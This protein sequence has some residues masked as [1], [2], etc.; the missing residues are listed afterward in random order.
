MSKLENL[1]KEELLEIVKEK[2]IAKKEEVEIYDIEINEKKLVFPLRIA[3]TD[4]ITGDK[5]TEMKEFVVTVSKE[6]QLA[7]IKLIQSYNIK[8]EVSD[9][10]ESTKTKNLETKLK[11]ARV[12]D[13]F[14]SKAF[15][16]LI[17]NAELASILFATENQE[18]AKKIMQKITDEM[19][20]F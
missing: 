10:N 8:V 16:L 15:S 13:D 3:K 4:L 14:I 7:Y 12:Y 18:V 6:L 5:V 1:T 19:A 20:N 2:E 11:N 17:S 9:F